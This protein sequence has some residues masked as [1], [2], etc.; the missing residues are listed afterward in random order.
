MARYRSKELTLIERKACEDQSAG[1][2][3]EEQAVEQG[4]T[5]QAI[6]KRVARAR[7]RMRRM[8]IEK[9]AGVIATPL[10]RI[11]IRP[12]SVQSWD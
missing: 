6:K 11:V 8:N 3:R 12:F 7:A 10:K 2:T 5:P 1:K 4:V 9:Y